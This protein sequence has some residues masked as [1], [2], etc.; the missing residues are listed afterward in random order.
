MS[1]RL[2]LSLCLSVVVVALTIFVQL[3]STAA[4]LSVNESATRSLIQD[5]TIVVLE[6]NNP[7]SQEVPVR[8]KLDLIDPDDVTRGVAITDIS[9]KTGANKLSIPLTLS[10]NSYQ[11]EEK[12]PWYRLR[13]QIQPSS[14]G[15]VVGA[16]QGFI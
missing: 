6:V 8:L 7:T 16:A 3:S 11:D 5:R 1:R 2:L 9:L 15:Q 12:V 13:Y 10:E 14:N 4:G